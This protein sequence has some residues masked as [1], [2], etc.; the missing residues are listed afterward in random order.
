MADATDPRPLVPLPPQPDGVSWPVD[1]WPTAPV[2]GGVD[3]DRLLDEV[4]ADDGELT[5]TLAAL[6]VHRGAIVA[7]R[8]R[9]ADGIDAS[10]TLISWSMAKSI[11]HALVGILVG[12]GSLAAG[13]HP[14]V[15]EW[16]PPDDPRR[17]I[18]LEHLLTMRDGLDFVED[19]VDD[20]VSDV[21]EMLF[22]AGQ[23]DVAA[24]AADRPLAHEPGTFFNY[25]SGTTNVV[26]RVVRDVVGAGDAYEAFIREELFD[27]LGMRSATPKFDDAGTFIASSFVYATARDFARF[28]LLYLRDGVWGDR[29]ILPEGWVDHARRLRSRDD[30]TG[31]G[32]GA[33]WWVLGDDTGA[34]WANGYEGQSILVSPALDLV[35]V[36]LG[37][38]PAE[39]SPALRAWRQRVLD[40]FAAAEPGSTDG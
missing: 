24:F 9:G 12:R 17:A 16:G 26:S 2:P 34:F 18:T 35:V 13:D 27:P 28:G 21:I 3:L 37:K 11:L 40:A 4:M 23:H 31:N 8:Y 32:Y 10:S 5:T 20:T 29:R 1:E 33:Q 19:Y 15:P 22:G 7:E 30:E 6:V 39:R 25:S 38:T 14:Q 36:R